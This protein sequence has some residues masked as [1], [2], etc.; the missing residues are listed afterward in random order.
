MS[1]NS[2]REIAG[3]GWGNQRHAA[4]YFDSSQSETGWSLPAFPTQGRFQQ[5]PKPRRLAIYDAVPPSSP[6]VVLFHQVHVEYSMEVR[7]G[8]AGLHWL[9]VV[10][11]EEDQVQRGRH[12]E[13][14]SEIIA[15]SDW[16][17]QAL[18]TGD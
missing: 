11:F 8:I 10:L 7:C 2:D 18:E 16:S 15:N 17:L 3:R 14:G 4:K 12:L 5:E 6:R 1:R 9:I 13:L